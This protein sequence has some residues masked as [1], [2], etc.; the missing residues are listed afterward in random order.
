MGNNSSIWK[1]NILRLFIITLILLNLS[2]LFKNVP[3]RMSERYD[4]F[5]KEKK[6]KTQKL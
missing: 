1:N 4:L 6:Y 5:K 2:W 3:Y